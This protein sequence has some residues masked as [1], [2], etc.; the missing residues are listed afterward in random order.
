MVRTCA[1]NHIVEINDARKVLKDLVGDY[2]NKWIHST[3]KEI[4]MARVEAAVSS[5]RSLFKPFA[6]KPPFES[7]KDIFCLREERVADA[8]RKISFHN[9]KFIVPKALPR[10]IIDLR[11]VPNV[12]K[13]LAEIRMWNRGR[14]ASAQLAKHEDIGLL[15]F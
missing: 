1:K 6:I 7:T 2:N 8:Y 12:K 10:D 9:A 15:H 13:G 5:G 14:L 11:I 3:T 4:P